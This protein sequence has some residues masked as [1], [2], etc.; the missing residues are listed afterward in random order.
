[1]TFM[2]HGARGVRGFMVRVKKQPKPAGGFATVFG[3]WLLGSGFTAAEVAKQISIAPSQVH[4][5]KTGEVRPSIRV[6]RRI[7]ALTKDA[8]TEADWPEERMIRPRPV[9]A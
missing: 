3:R 2:P 4:R 7:R 9:P 8:V 6:M 5:Y 1:M